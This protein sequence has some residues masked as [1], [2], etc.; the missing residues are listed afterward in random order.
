MFLLLEG[1]VER[2]LSDGCSVGV[3]GAGECLG[4]VAL[5]S[6]ADHAAT[7][8]ARREVHAGVIRKQDLDALVRQRPDIGVA[9]YRN[10]AEGVGSKLRQFDLD[11]VAESGRHPEDHAGASTDAAAD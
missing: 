7:A 3:A 5:L 4:E 6:G 1:E 2:V 10:L 9:L 11:H 8:T